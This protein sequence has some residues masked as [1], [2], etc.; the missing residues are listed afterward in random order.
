MF[1]SI[2]VSF[3]H[4]FKINMKCLLLILKVLTSE[5]VKKGYLTLCHSG[6]CTD[7]E[8]RH[9]SNP[10]R[11]AWIVSSPEERGSLLRWL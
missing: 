7:L 1:S 4:A 8:L 3:E 6:R 5:D 9:L 11:M 2:V 10:A